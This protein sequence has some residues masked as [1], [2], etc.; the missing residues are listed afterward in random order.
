MVSGVAKD[1][2]LR[3]LFVAGLGFAVLSAL[4]SRIEWLASFCSL[5]GDGCSETASVSLFH[6]PIPIWGMVYYVVLII[7]TF[8][9][10]EWLFF[11]VMA[12][13]GIELTLISMMIEMKWVC[14]FCLLNL[15]VVILSVIFL[16]ENRRIWQALAI[17]VICFM[18]S[19]H[20]LTQESLGLPSVRPKAPEPSVVAR[21]GDELIHEQELN[22]A[23][24][25]QIYKLERQIYELKMDRLEYLI[26]SKL[27]ALDAKEK[28]LSPEVY[29]FKVFNEAAEV[30]DQDVDQYIQ[31]NPG[32]ETNW[33]GREDELRK[34]VKDY[35]KSIKAKENIDK[36]TAPLKDKFPVEIFLEQPALP[37][38]SISQGSSPA[39]GPEEA[40]VVVYEFSDYQCPSC[41]KMHQVSLKIR[42]KYKGK[43]KWI[44]KDYPLDRHKDAWPMAQA[45]WCAKEQDKFWEY[46]EF[47][48]A[49]EGNP[50]LETYKGFA[51]KLNL[52]VDQFGQCFESG[53]YKAMIE[54]EKLEGKEAGVSSTPS[55][56]ING[57]LSPGFISFEKMSDWINQELAK[58][59]L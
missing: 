18:A 43:I 35:L 37:V 39:I 28:G 58:D 13:A 56:V 24:S 11:I 51:K 52:D 32:I 33:K 21:V 17:S 57:R 14:V 4:E 5:W 10:S 59:Q 8:V 49:V 46:Q 34:R 53:K 15:V 3:V 27:I 20:L 30:T 9:A 16:Y 38:T 47:L 2:L 29:T 25:S 26:D 48:Y 6:L 55:F 40:S 7:F 42:K 31:G 44:F 19:D 12:G 36:V 54:R 1:R 45:A 41:R 23:L 22:E 50:D